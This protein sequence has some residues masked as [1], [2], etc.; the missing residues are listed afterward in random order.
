MGKA[1]DVFHKDC[2]SS[3]PA[4]AKRRS[5]SNFQSEPGRVL[6]D[7]AIKMWAPLKLKPLGVS[8]F[9]ANQPSACRNLSKLQLKYLYQLMTPEAS[10]AGK[11]ISAVT[12]CLSSLWILEVTCPANSILC[13]VLEKSSIFSLFSFFLLQ[14][15]EWQLLNSCHS[16]LKWQV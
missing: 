15:L 11:Q 2:S 5:F 14:G 3:P 12:L 13:L 16:E 6:I 9:Y 7:K 10:S 4:G 1:M 8:H